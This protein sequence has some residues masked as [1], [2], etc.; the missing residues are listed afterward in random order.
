MNLSSM[1]LSLSHRFDSHPKRVSDSWGASI[2]KS[3]GQARVIST[4]IRIMKRRR[5]HLLS[6]LPAVLLA[7]SAYATEPVAPANDL[8]NPECAD[9]ADETS[10]AKAEHPHWE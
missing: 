8:Q 2:A 5:L 9:S 3:D 4:R 1:L 10:D 7:L 6:S